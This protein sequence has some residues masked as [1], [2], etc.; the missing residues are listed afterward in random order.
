MAVPK[1]LKDFL[2]Y[3]TVVRGKSKRTR[4]EY[5]YDILLLF[6][7]L[8]MIREDI[9][10]IEDTNVDNIN[11]DFISETSLEELYAF[12]EYCE[13][14][15][16]NSPHAKAR[17]VASIKSYFKY[18]YNKRKLLE[19]NIADELETPKIG[20]RS[21]V[22]MNIDEVKDF[23]NGINKRHYYRNYCIMMLF[24]NCG[25]RVSEL[26][27]LDVSSINENI[28]RVIGKGN[29]ERI[30][31]LNETC[32]NSIDEY[33]RKERSKYPNIKDSEA[34]FISQKGNRL[35][36]RTVQ[37]IVKKIN[38]NSINKKNLTPHKLRHT[39]AT[40]LYQNGADLRSLQQILGHSSVSTTEIY[41]HVSNERIKKVME[42]NPLNEN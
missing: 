39:M 5:E 15:R 21:P 24:L 34:L 29:K 26:C 1:I 6:R 14:V 19:M 2:I 36:P 18:L 4:K 40:M 32:L 25:L 27:N 42:N 12:L 7:F 30:V 37:T 3:T 23:L 31:Y 8:K 17:K 35:S 22:Y 20:K 28:L 13:E 33:I 11:I 9:D 38:K 16:N 10:N 41:T